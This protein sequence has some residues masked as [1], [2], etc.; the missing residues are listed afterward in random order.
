[1]PTGGKANRDFVFKVLTTPQFHNSDFFL[2][3]HNFPTEQLRRIAPT[4][5]DRERKCVWTTWAFREIIK[6]RKDLNCDSNRR[7]ERITL[8]LNEGGGRR[9]LAPPGIKPHAVH[10][11]AAVQHKN[12]IT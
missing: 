10:L 5:R 4:D 9:F 1:L 8:L 12:W 6:G 11:L 2:F 3:T 7:N